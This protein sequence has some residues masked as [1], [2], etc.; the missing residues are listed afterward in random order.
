MN[1]GVAMKFFRTI[2]S[3][4]NVVGG[5]LVKGGVHLLGSAVEKKFPKTGEYIK[6]VGD[7]V[8]HSSQTVL[9]NTSHFADGATNGLYGVV[10]KNQSRKEDGW[11]DVKQSTVKTAKGIGGGLVYTGKSVGQTFTGVMNKDNVQI[12]E[13]AKN[14]GKVGAVA[15]VGVGVLDF[16]VDTDVVSAEELEFDTR[17]GHLEGSTH[18]VTGV[19]FAENTVVNDYGSLQT[20]AFPVF[21]AA[22]DATLPPETVQMSDTV[23]IGIANMQL[24]DAIEAN[25]GLATELGFDAADIEALKSSVTPEGYDWHHHEEAGR[26]Q[27]IEEEVHSKTGHTGGR[28]IWAGGT[29]AR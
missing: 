3:G 17:N 11:D 5:G 8:V 20:G 13:G 9:S 24:A 29:E 25:P 6:E 10:T 16:I 7:T 27:L 2:G 4:V 26:M 15:L 19:Q 12:V 28:A 23:H 14:L 22:Y 21:D 18:A 1:G